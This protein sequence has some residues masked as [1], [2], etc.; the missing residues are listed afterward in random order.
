LGLKGRNQGISAEKSVITPIDPPGRT[1]K[2]GLRGRGL[3]T[4]HFSRLAFCPGGWLDRGGTMRQSKELLSVKAENP[5]DGADNL[6]PENR[7]IEEKRV[8]IK[9]E[10]GS[11]VKGKI[12]ILSE[13]AHEFDGFYDKH[14]DDQGAYY[15]RISD[16]F[17]K[18]KHPFV[19]VFDALMENE[20]GQVLIINKKKISWVVPED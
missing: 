8:T 2:L 16:I 3:E 13:P 15:R 1:D 6:V 4:W 9:L 14:L 10:D 7:S 18:G 11:L 20:A 12:N 17:T 5:G 19:V